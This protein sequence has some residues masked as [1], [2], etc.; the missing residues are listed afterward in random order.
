METCLLESIRLCQV[1][2]EEY[3][4]L[5][6]RTGG[7]FLDAIEPFI[8]AIDKRQRLLEDLDRRI[9]RLARSERPQDRDVADLVQARLAQMQRLQALQQQLL[10]R[11]KSCQATLKDELARLRRQMPAIRSYHIQQH[12]AATRDRRSTPIR[13]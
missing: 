11:L 1:M 4:G 13:A 8:S 7:D 10:K 5:L 6:A 9:D 12:Q 2:A 3:E